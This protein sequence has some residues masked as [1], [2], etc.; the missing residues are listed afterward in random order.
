MTPSKGDTPPRPNTSG[1]LDTAAVFVSQTGHLIFGLATQS[2]LAYTLLPE[3]RGAFALCVVF[4]T[5]LGVLFT[6]G[7]QQ[8]TQH[9]V[10]T[11]QA[12]VSEAVCSALAICLIGAV[13]GIALAVPFIHSGVAFF[14]KAET[15]AF[16][17]ALALVPLMTFSVAMEHQLAALRRFG[18]LAVISLSHAIANV[19]LVGTLVWLW[20][21]GVAGALWGC[22]A[23]HALTVALCIWY[24]RRHHGLVATNPFRPLFARI[25]G[26]G[27]RF[28]SARIGDALEGS[29]G[30]LV[31]GLLAN[32]AE[33]GL[34]A[35]ASALVLRLRLISNAVGNALL[36]RIAGTGHPELTTRCL[37]LVCCATL[38]ALLA[39]LAVGT[40]LV[41]IL[42]SEAF[43]PATPL[44]WI[45]A[46][47]VL[48]FAGAG[49]LMTYFKGINRPGICSWAVSLGLAVNLVAL[50]LLY[51]A[52]GIAAAGWALSLGMVC[53]CVFLAVAFGR[54]TG[55]SGPAA[56]LPRPGDAV[57]T[58]RAL[59]TMHG[60][61]S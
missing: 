26:F 18:V 15:Q 25:L 8:G 34:F 16:H 5:A 21:F 33:I 43:L 13:A 54:A 24:L 20:G 52:L 42:F 19:L 47:G 36:P 45:I 1:G 11:R 51:P 57:F 22:A 58:W 27:L 9:F 44:L 10:M 35:A 30:I 46:P 55:M 28:H 31:L 6:P 7:A 49:I 41:R 40:P 4:A 3:G 60:R 29:L 53:R 23:A 14:Q 48:A 32:Q 59:R 2:I 56:W 61:L 38:A 39:L 37:R 17:L 12:T 50:P